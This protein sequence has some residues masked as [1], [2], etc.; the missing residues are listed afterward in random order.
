MIGMI[1]MMLYHRAGEWARVF[2][3]W[4]VEGNV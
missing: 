4:L 1:G 3:S 2:F